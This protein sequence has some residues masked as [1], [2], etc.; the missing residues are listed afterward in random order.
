MLQVGDMVKMIDFELHDRLPIWYPPVGTCGIVL[1]VFDNGRKL[2]VQ[3]ERGSTSGNDVWSV[4]S[5]SV[6]GV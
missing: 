6:Q 5:E 2:R 1:Q 3:W 4:L